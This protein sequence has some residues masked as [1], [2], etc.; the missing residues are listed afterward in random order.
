MPCGIRS[1]D[2]R[3]YSREKDARFSHGRYVGCNPRVF[4]QDTARLILTGNNWSLA[5]RD[6][7]KATTLAFAVRSFITPIKKELLVFHRPGASACTTLLAIFVT[8]IGRA[9]CWL[10]V[11]IE[12]AMINI[13]PKLFEDKRG[14]VDSNVQSPLSAC[15]SEATLT[16]WIVET[17]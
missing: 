7:A 14:R 5:T 11:A 15:V 13:G 9:A 12:E 8:E 6:K 2:G 17:G 16:G 1:L 4:L 10:L 3:W